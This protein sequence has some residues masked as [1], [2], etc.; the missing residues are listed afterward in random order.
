MHRPA[1][2][3]IAELAERRGAAFERLILEELYLLET[4]LAL[5]RAARE[6]EPGIAL[7]PSARADAERR[8]RASRSGSPARRSARRARSAPTSRARTR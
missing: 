8:A 7:A 6:R 4:G 2:D 3:E 1:P 5:R